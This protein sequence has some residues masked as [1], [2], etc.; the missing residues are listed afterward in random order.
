MG[1]KKLTVSQ[2]QEIIQRHLIIGESQ[3]SLAPQYG[4]SR[5]LICEIVKKYK[6]RH[7]NSLAQGAAGLYH[8]G[9]EARNQSRFTHPSHISSVNV[10][11]TMQAIE[12][13]PPV[14]A[15][16][17]F[18]PHRPIMVLADWQPSAAGPIYERDAPAGQVQ[19]RIGAGAGSALF[20]PALTELT[21]ANHSGTSEIQ[22]VFQRQ[23]QPASSTTDIEKEHQNPQLSRG[24]LE[25]D[26]LL[27]SR[28]RQRAM[29]SEDADRILEKLLGHQLFSIDILLWFSN[30]GGLTSYGFDKE[31]L[32]MLLL[33]DDEWR[34]KS[35]W[36]D[37]FIT[38]LPPQ[39]QDSRLVELFKTAM[40][41]AKCIDGLQ[42]LHRLYETVEGL[43]LPI[44]HIL[45]RL[46][47]QS[48]SPWPAEP[49][50][51]DAV[52]GSP[53]GQISLR[54]N[55]V[56]SSAKD[57][58]APNA[59][60]QIVSQ[61]N[62]DNLSSADAASPAGMTS[63]PDPSTSALQAA[64]LL[65]SLREKADIQDM[66]LLT[67][68][69]PVAGE[70][71]KV[72]FTEPLRWF[73]GT[74]KEFNPSN[75]KGKIKFVDGD[76]GIFNLGDPDVVFSPTDANQWRQTCENDLG[77]KILRGFCTLCSEALHDKESRRCSRCKITGY[78]L[79]C[80]GSSPPAV[81]LCPFCRAEFADIGRRQAPQV[82]DDNT[83]S[84]MRLCFGCASSIPVERKRMQADRCKDCNALFCY[85]CSSRTRNIPVEFTCP[86]CIG[87]SAHDTVLRYCFEL[88]SDRLQLIIETRRPKHGGKKQT[89]A[90]QGQDA[91]FMDEFALS[92]SSLQDTCQWDLLEKYLPVAIQQLRHQVRAENDPSMGPFHQL[93]LLGMDEGPD[94]DLVHQA[95]RLYAYHEGEKAKSQPHCSK[96]C[97]DWRFVTR[98]DPRSSGRRMGFVTADMRCTPWWQLSKVY[99]L[100]LATRNTL[101]VY[102]RP[103]VQLMG[104]PYYEALKNQCTIIE[105]D[106]GA[107][108]AAVAKVI[109]Q[110]NLDVL[111][112]EGGPTYGSFTGVMSLLPDI[113]RGAHLGYP[114]TQPGGHIDF[115]VVDQHVVPPGSLQAER[116]EE[117]LMFLRCYQPND[118]FSPSVAI[119]A[120]QPVAKTNRSDWNLPD[121]SFVFAHFCRPGR[122][123]KRLIETFAEILARAPN[124]RLWMRNSPLPAVLRIKKFFST[125]KIAKDRIIF[126][127]DVPNEEHRERTGHADLCLDSDIYCGHTTCSD[128]LLRGVPYLVLSGQ[129]WHGRVSS[130]L[131]SNMMGSIASEFVCSDLL[132]FQERAVFFATGGANILKQHQATLRS[133]LDSGSG[134]CDGQ[135]W[136]RDFQKGIDEFVRQKQ[137]GQK[138]TDVF[139]CEVIN[140]N[141]TQRERKVLAAQGNV[142][143]AECCGSAW[144][145]L[146]PVRSLQVESRANIQRDVAA[147]VRKR[148]REP[149]E[150]CISVKR[151]KKSQSSLP[152]LLSAASVPS[153]DEAS[154]DEPEPQSGD[155]VP[156]AGAACRTKAEQHRIGWLFDLAI[157]NPDEARKAAYKYLMESMPK[158]RDIAQCEDADGS[159]MWAIQLPCKRPRVSSKTGVTK[160]AET[161]FP[162]LYVGKAVQGRGSDLYCGQG[163]EE[164]M[165][166]TGYDGVL[167]RSSNVADRTHAISVSYAHG[168]AIDSGQTPDHVL[169]RHCSLGAKS[170]HA[171][172]ESNVRYVRTEWTSPISQHGVSIYLKAKA[173]GAAHTKILGHYTSGA[174][175]RDHNIARNPVAEGKDCIPT[176]EL[177]T[178]HMQSPVTEA[179]EVLRKHAG[180]DLV[181][182]R[183]A[184]SEGVVV[185]VRQPAT[186]KT[187]V[188][189]IAREAYDNSNRLGL[190]EAALLYRVTQQQQHRPSIGTFSLALQT[191]I[192]WG[193]CGAALLRASEKLVAAVAM[194]R[195]DSDA[196]EIWR[197]LRT[198]FEQGEDKELLRDQQSVL[199]GTIQATAWMHESGLAHGDL[200]SSNIL[201]IRLAETPEDWRVA[202]CVVQGVV[203]QIV[204]GDWGHARWSG[205]TDKVM[206]VFTTGDRGG[207]RHWTADLHDGEERDKIIPIQN[208]KLSSAFG[209]LLRVPSAFRHPGKGTVMIRA[210]H[211]VRDFSHG[212]GVAQ[213]SF[214]QAADMWALGVISV[215][216][217]AW[218]RVGPGQ[219]DYDGKEWADRLR[220]ASHAAEKRLTAVSRCGSER[221]SQAMEASLRSKDFGSWI[222]AMVR[223]RY[224]SDR[225]PILSGRLSGQHGSGWMSLL[226]LQHG[227]LRYS[228][229]NRLKAAKALDHGFLCKQ[230]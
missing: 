8:E 82:W 171:W 66:N 200:K 203:Y 50:D 123:S 29:T 214:D 4:V 106:G 182:L 14:T 93:N 166:L 150:A 145:S 224:S 144:S 94:F 168:Q 92:I 179:M 24:A 35:A 2:E 227:L 204:F 107:S 131:V 217:F 125:K 154:S 98:K 181:C 173:G 91:V 146:A 63:G 137:C 148:G 1:P 47:E 12:L 38:S 87:I 72:I 152:V 139:L 153:I 23:I 151:S 175:V 205:A 48:A 149:D 76:E 104:D 89:G 121:N 124:S 132:Q 156:Q 36:L 6:E 202:F 138:F 185:E 28:V 84:T 193:S 183:G 201:L 161:E 221:G 229:E 13:T 46:S 208:R 78:H 186:S 53:A 34:S 20:A 113:L 117:A 195:A 110:A 116:A 128:A 178:H 212:E 99:L 134:I 37:Q 52:D 111:M 159:L 225:W 57:Q 189:K 169:L 100:E 86:S 42:D 62:R 218:P 216:V 177:R 118:S 71:V 61:D 103:F 31:E 60:D 119:A 207:R 147:T 10:S 226:D 95:S 165:I 191:E 45:R 101:F 167:L 49:P 19:D 69:S 114:G 184:G 16:G 73:S 122:I 187:F 55:E 127:C 54:T 18:G 67:R 220:K 40:R 140:H 74:V 215:C 51:S 105:F 77:D 172:K 135:S 206:H 43:P 75:S 219:K 70:E 96:K 213:R 133:R 7:N 44:K 58:A 158:G 188:V 199:R 9:N 68:P 142:N 180:F 141:A 223:Q 192:G 194:E 174:A 136:I 155:V 210:P 170:N 32:S 222:A 15:G 88:N 27:Q 115:T 22:G 21:T 41:K 5:P 120:V 211:H 198:R 90:Q 59:D 190:A 79:K 109:S 160:Q 39:L 97:S 102:S 85:C 3:Q 81:F 196:T 209:H 83:S 143:D 228:S 30:N 65:L 33:D 11:R 26:Q 108:D 163:F 157:E 129:W 80:L 112:D 126:A 162:L 64:R 130:S 164:G 56:L 197:G 176:E 17:F 25:L 230:H